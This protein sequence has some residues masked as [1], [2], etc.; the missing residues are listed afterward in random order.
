[1]EEAIQ[2]SQR[3]KLLL[4][5]LLRCHCASLQVCVQRLSLSPTLRAVGHESKRR[6]KR[7]PGHLD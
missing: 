2:R 5:H 7:V 1:V 6:S 4:Q 3:L